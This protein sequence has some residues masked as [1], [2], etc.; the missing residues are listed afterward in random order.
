MH[1]ARIP[2]QIRFADVDMARHVHNGVYLHWF[3]LARMELLKSVVP[4]DNDWAVTGL[5]L[6][7]N[8]VDHRMPV[9][10][11]DTITA[12]AWCSAIGNKSFDLSYRIV[13]HHGERTEVCAEGRSV[14]V[15]YDHRQE[16]SI[17]VPDAWRAALNA[18]P[19]SR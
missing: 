18:T 9:R 16:R 14:M 19:P 7:R 1:I 15:C 17:P 11:N 8:E 3:E 6:A 2:I 10:L 4:A 13:R 5:I 12:E